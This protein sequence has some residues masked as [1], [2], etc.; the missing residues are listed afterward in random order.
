MRSALLAIAVGIITSAI[1]AN[2]SAQFVVNGPDGSIGIANANGGYDY[3]YPDR[4]N[5][6]AN[7]PIPG[8][9]INTPSGPIWR[10][11]DGKIHG[12]LLDPSTGDMHIRMAPAA[13]ATGKLP[14]VSRHVP[15]QRLVAPPRRA[16]VPMPPTSYH[17]ADPYRNSTTTRAVPPSYRN[18]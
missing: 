3:Y 16:A 8:S 10:G 4:M 9:T 15:G 5:P 13:P 17:K 12:H 1:G 11:L 2:A 18:R 6:L 14:P 7:I